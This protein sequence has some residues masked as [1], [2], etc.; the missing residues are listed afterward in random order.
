MAISKKARKFPPKSFPVAFLL[1]NVITLAGLCVG[2]SGIR[3]AMHGRYELAVAFILLAALIDG[4]DGRLARMLNA[5]STFGAHLDSLADFVSF[6]IAP[7]M[8]VYLW[9]LENIPRY[10]WMAV[11][12]CA[13]CTALRLARFNTTHIFDTPPPS[14]EEPDKYFTGVPA[15]AGA[16]LC[17][18]PMVLSFQFGEGWYSSPYFNL[19]YVPIISLMMASTIP[20]FS[21]KKFKIK[22][23][24]AAPFMAFSG[25]FIAGCIIEP[26]FTFT[27]IAAIYLALIP[28][29]MIQHRRDSTASE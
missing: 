20:T 23:N 8:I 3:W 18:A 22:S 5:T 17:I 27:I 24:M 15:P 2:L 14:K 26:W 12:V 4:M 19:I 21:I 9:Q 28:F 11:L 1:P 16:L 29:S 6:G 10:G 13:V 25:L 7:V